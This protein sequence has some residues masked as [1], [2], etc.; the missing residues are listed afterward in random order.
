MEGAPSNTARFPSIVPPTGGVITSPV[1]NALATGGR[2]TAAVGAEAAT[3]ES[4][5]I[6]IVLGGGSGKSVTVPSLSESGSTGSESGALHNPRLYVSWAVGRA[7]LLYARR[8]D[9][10]GPGF[11]PS[12][13]SPQRTLRVLLTFEG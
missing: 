4:H 13:P 6:S 3:S 5:E 8:V 2:K 9:T 11:E 1:W 7:C 10:K 12:Y